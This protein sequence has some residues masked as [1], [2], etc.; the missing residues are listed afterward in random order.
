MTE[1]YVLSDKEGM[2][3]Y[4]RET[5]INIQNPL[6]SLPFS[7]FFCKLRHLFEQPVAVR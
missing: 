5:P 6:L 4:R 7:L 2:H 3:V 1:V